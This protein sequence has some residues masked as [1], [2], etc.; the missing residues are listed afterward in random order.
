MIMTFV[1]LAGFVNN[2]YAAEHCEHDKDC[3]MPDA[4]CVRNICEPSCVPEE[5]NTDFCD[6]TDYKDIYTKGSVNYYDLKGCECVELN[7]EETCLNGNDE[8][9]A[10]PDLLEYN[11][12]CRS[13]GRVECDIGC[14]DGACLPVTAGEEC[15][16]PEASD[17]TV[18][19]CMDGYGK[20]EESGCA[21]G[22]MCH[23]AMACVRLMDDS[24]MMP[25]FAPG[26]KSNNN[27]L[28]IILAVIVIAAIGG[29]LYTKKK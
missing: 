15:Y 28:Y 10:G 19:E 29:Y 27:M 2:S 1:L 26:Q 8:V 9:Y 6:N 3:S 13:S 25:T 17:G 11:E 20:S 4:R 18:F 14:E 7:L 5:C 23:S 24:A 16:C 22:E 12:Q 21:D